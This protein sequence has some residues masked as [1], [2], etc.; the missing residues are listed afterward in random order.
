VKAG[1]CPRAIHCARSGHLAVCSI[2]HRCCAD[3][4]GSREQIC[5]GRALSAPFRVSARQPSKRLLATDRGANYAAHTRC[6]ASGHLSEG[7]DAMPPTGRRIQ[8]CPQAARPGPQRA[9]APCQQGALG[10]CGHRHGQSA[11]HCL[12]RP[13]RGTPGTRC[14]GRIE[15]ATPLLCSPAAPVI[16]L[17]PL[18]R[19]P[20]PPLQACSTPRTTRMHAEWVSSAS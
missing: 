15:T 1:S 12:S 10:S 19:H 9:P 2:P 13:R 5:S 6:L 14:A 3:L 18:N 8:G 17:D 7:E 20:S 11:R 4:R 16:E